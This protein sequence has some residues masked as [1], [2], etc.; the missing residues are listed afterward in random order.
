MAEDRGISKAYQER[1][2]QFFRG[3]SYLRR[4]GIECIGGAFVIHLSVDIEFKPPVGA[5][6]IDGCLS[7]I[8]GEDEDDEYEGDDPLRS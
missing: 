1:L 6:I 4:C 2:D 3:D 7:A 8:M 5:A